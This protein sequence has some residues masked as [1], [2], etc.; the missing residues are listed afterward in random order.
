[1]K[2]AGHTKIPLMECERCDSAEVWV[3]DCDLR[4]E[5]PDG[6]AEG[7][8]LHFECGRCGDRE[9]LEYDDDPKI[10]GIGEAVARLENVS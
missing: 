4:T 9:M 3:L 7:T 10:D 8:H 6:I 2:L 5:C 1:M